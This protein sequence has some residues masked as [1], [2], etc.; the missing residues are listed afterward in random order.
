MLILLYIR[1]S[2][3]PTCSKNIKSLFERLKKYQSFCNIDERDYMNTSALAELARLLPAFQVVVFQ[4]KEELKEQ[5]DYTAVF[6]AL[7][8]TNPDADI[9]SLLHTEGIKFDILKSKDGQR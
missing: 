6:S 9:L 1:I 3:D 5:S 7:S 4:K 2:S 8:S